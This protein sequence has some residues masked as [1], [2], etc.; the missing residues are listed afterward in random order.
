MVGLADAAAPPALLAGTDG[1]A[2]EDG[3]ALAAGGAELGGFGGA[4]A[5]LLPV[6]G[7]VLGTGPACWL[8]PDDPQAERS[9]ASRSDRS[10]SAA[11]VRRNRARGG[12]PGVTRLAQLVMCVRTFR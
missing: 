12:L 1:A 6:L 3:A 9:A 4:G 11:A 2:E 5:V 7:A 10:V 8:V